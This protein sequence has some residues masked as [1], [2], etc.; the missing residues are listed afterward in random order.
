MATRPRAAPAPEVLDPPPNGAEWRAP[1]GPAANALTAPD[2]EDLDD[3]GEDAAERIRQMLA[4]SGGDVRVK[5]YR[6]DPRTARLQWCCDL[7]PREFETGGLDEIRAAWGAGD[8]E[9]RV[10]GPKGIMGRSRFSIAKQE[11][12]TQLAT[13]QVATTVD[14]TLAAILGKMAESQAVMMELVK[15]I[16]EK[17][18][19]DPTASMSAALGLMKDMREAMGLNAPPPP[20]PPVSDPATM[21]GTLVNAFKTMKEAASEFGAK[22]EPEDSLTGLAGKVIE[23]VG[24]QLGQ[25]LPQLLQGGAPSQPLP[26]IVAPASLSAAPVASNPVNETAPEPDMPTPI[27]VLVLRGTLQGL[28]EQARADGP[29]EKGGEFIADKLPQEMLPYLDL[30]NWSEVLQ[31]AAVHIG[32]PIPVECLPWIDRAR[33]HALKLLSEDDGS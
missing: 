19:P 31:A 32:V 20:A 26:T 7:H 33:Q 24:P 9:V 27:E 21:L 11:N 17:P 10:I 8:F 29:T 30:P 18:A 16:A 14:P 23:M 22:P 2:L 25:A 15:S 12:P 5:V 6:T 28:I 4:T 13:A 1:A 3:E